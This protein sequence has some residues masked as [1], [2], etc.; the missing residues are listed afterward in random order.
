MAVQTLLLVKVL[1]LLAVANG[2]PVIGQ[3]IFKDRF[4][5]PLDAGV[6]F[7][8][9]RPLLGRSKTL[10]GVLLSLVATALAAPA[11]GFG[12]DIGFAVGFFAMLGDATSSFI[13]RRLAMPSSSMAL[14]IDQIPESLFPL[15][16]VRPALGLSVDDIAIL[17]AT[18]LVLELLLS[19]LLFR[20][21]LRDRP[22]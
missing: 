17:V 3:K 4:R 2:T 8:D 11:L 20:L 18:F 21:H 14:G 12:F 7:F 19:R 10:R 5:F 6:R 15:L 16:A 9:G 13:K 1:L 22:Y